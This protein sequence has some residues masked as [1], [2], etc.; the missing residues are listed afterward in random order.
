MISHAVF[1]QVQQSQAAHLNSYPHGF[2]QWTCQV[3]HDFPLISHVFFPPSLWTHHQTPIFPILTHNF[4]IFSHIF[5]RFSHVFSLLTQVSHVFAPRTCHWVSWASRTLRPG[6]LPVKVFN[7]YD[8]VWENTIQK[9]TSTIT[10][11]NCI[12]IL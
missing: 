6:I 9:N 7:N 12:Y 11:Y 2:F 10:V 3:I 1:L 8:I 5:P 4:P